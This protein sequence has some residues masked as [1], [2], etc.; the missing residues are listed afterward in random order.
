VIAGDNGTIII[1]EKMEEAKN[2]YSKLAILPNSEKKEKEKGEFPKLMA[3]IM[4]SRIKC[5]SLS[6]TDDCIVFTT[7]NN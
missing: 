7:D 6:S 3:G 1:Y 4:T 2:P 5:M